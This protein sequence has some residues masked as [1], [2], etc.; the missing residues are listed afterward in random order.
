MGPS[1]CLPT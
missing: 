1:C